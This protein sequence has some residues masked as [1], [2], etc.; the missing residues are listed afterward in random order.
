MARTIR[1]LTI[2]LELVRSVYSLHDL[3]MIAEGL[4][5][6][7]SL[8]ASWPD[9]A[10]YRFWPPEEPRWLRQYDRRGA[11]TARVVKLE[12]SSPPILTLL[13]T[14]EWIAVYLAIVFGGWAMVATYDDVKRNIPIIRNDVHSAIQGLQG[15]SERARRIITEVVDVFLDS[16]LQFAEDELETAL[17]RIRRIQESRLRL[18]APSEPVHKSLEVIED[19]ADQ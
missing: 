19:K 8:A 5:E 16:L 6:I 2:R 1:E 11:S 12:V 9:L 18:A 14:P 15:L 3:R 4:D 10:W 13:C 17:S 7:D